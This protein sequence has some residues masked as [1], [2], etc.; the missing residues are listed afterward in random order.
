MIYLHVTT[1]GEEA[2]IIM[3]NLNM[4]RKPFSDDE[5]V[6]PCVPSIG[7]IYRTYGPAYLKKFADKIIC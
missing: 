5:T 3:I 4:K 7:E 1:V 2:A 6:A